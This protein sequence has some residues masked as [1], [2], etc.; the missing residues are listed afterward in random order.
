MITAI[1]I[2]NF[3]RIGERVELELRPLLCRTS[4]PHSPNSQLVPFASITLTSALARDTNLVFRATNIT[5]VRLQ[6]G[7][8][9]RKI[10]SLR[11]HPTSQSLGPVVLG[12][13]EVPPFGPSFPVTLAQ[14]KQASL[15]SR[16]SASR[17]ALNHYPSR[18]Y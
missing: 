15:R 18:L 5:A 17:L 4:I 13:H 16:H 10:A 7:L 12:E 3:K 14:T 9:H 6:T 11:R 8:T 1:T 2:E